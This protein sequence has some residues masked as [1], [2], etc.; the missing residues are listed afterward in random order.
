MSQFKVL[1][2]DFMKLIEIYIFLGIHPDS[3]KYFKPLLA[4]LIGAIFGVLF[5]RFNLLWIVGLIA[6]PTVYFTTLY[7]LGFDDEDMVVLKAIRT[8]LTSFHR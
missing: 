2:I 7:F 5:I 8:K 4:G 1:I 6:L 3:K